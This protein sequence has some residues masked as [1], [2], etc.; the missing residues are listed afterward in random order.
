MRLDVRNDR[1]CIGEAHRDLARNQIDDCGP[2]AFVGDMHDVDSER[3]TEHH[4]GKM[5][6]AAA[7]VRAV[8]QFS[9]PAFRECDQL[10]HGA[11]GCGRGHD[12]NVRCR[13]QQGNRRVS[14]DRIVRQLFVERGIDGFRSYCYTLF[15]DTVGRNAIR[16]AFYKTLPYDPIKAYAPV[17]LLGTAP[18]IL[19]V[20]AATPVGTVRELVALAKSRPGKLTYGSNGI[21]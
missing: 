8:S 1:Q 9:G 7:A 11:G 6:G 16:P 14:L 17:S 3:G 18:N 19:V 10:A 20:P 4:A 21:G 2:C 12:Q 5:L 13:A 15:R